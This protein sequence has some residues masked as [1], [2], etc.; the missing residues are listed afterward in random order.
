M[1]IRNIY[2]ICFCLFISLNCLAQTINTFPNIERPAKDKMVTNAKN[3]KVQIGFGVCLKAILIK[4]TFGHFRLSVTGGIGKPTNLN[5]IINKSSIKNK[6][7][8]YYF[9]ELEFYNGGLGTSGL[10][11]N[12]QDFKIELRQSILASFGDYGTSNYYSYT[13]PI[14]QFVNS[15]SHPLLDPFNNFSFTI[16][17]IFINGIN[18]HRAQ[19]LGLVNIGILP[20]GL[21]Y[22]NDGPPFENKI[23]KL[24]D[25]FDRFWT[26]GGQI[27]IYNMSPRY[28]INKL[29]LKYD[30]FT[31]WFPY[32]YEVSTRLGLRYVPYH[33]KKDQLYNRQKYEL[34]ITGFNGLGISYNLYDFPNIDMQHL[35]HVKNGYTLHNTPLARRTAPAIF[36]DNTFLI[37][38]K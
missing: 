3:N 34:S 26:G 13:R 9:S 30:K 32:G 18:Y 33:D 37:I 38:N 11:Y 24:G 35:I 27:G 28:R 7:I 1:I 10:N 6:A 25:G 36:Y 31:G 17:T 16:G 5:T 21:T 22:I 4:K 2:L 12:S 14:I 8:F 20:I 23:L 19:R 15:S 29:E